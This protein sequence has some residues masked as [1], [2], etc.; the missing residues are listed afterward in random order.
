MPKYHDTLLLV[1]EHRSAMKYCKNLRSSPML[2]IFIMLMLAQ[3]LS[4]TNLYLGVK[5]QHAF[6]EI[7]GN[8]T[9]LTENAVVLN[10]MGRFNDALSYLDK[11]LSIDPNNVL[12]LIN[13]GISLDGL[14]RF[15]EEMMY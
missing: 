7:S 11:A 13:K 5:D 10:S 9:K 8:V 12:A 6:G 15:D 2:A 3:V 4:I 14:G 1:S